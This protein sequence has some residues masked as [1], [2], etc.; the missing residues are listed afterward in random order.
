MGPKSVRNPIQPRI[1]AKMPL[2]KV[3]AT[4]QV[5]GALSMRV[6]RS[7]LAA[8]SLVALC[9]IAGAAAIAAE[10]T[11]EEV[12]K[13]RGL[14]RSGMLYV[15]EAESE[16]VPKVA[17]LQP[18][19]RQLKVQYDKVA[20]VMQSQAE[21]DALDDRWTLVN[22]Q[23]RD[24][25]AEIDAHPPTSNNELKQSWQNLLEAERQLRFQYNELRRE[26]NL[27]YKRL[28]SDSEKEKLQGDFLKQRD[29]FLESSRELRALAGKVRDDYSALS[30]DDA[31]KKAL[32]ALKVSAKGSVNLGPS[33]DFK[34]ASAWLINAVRST[35]PESLAPRG[36]KKNANK[37][38]ASTK[39]K[40]TAPAKDRLSSRAQQGARANPPSSADPEASPK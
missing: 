37:G 5:R 22:E 4:G 29:D 33:P 6:T 25:Q 26:V 12:L 21:Y 39:G 16:F 32:T 10:Q 35:S 36:R 24:V 17:K 3:V 27:R 1:I 34:K 9:A 28:V 30:H 23:L 38:K 2:G 20:T 13:S 14:K 31:V 15:L 18:S 19:Y 11:P 7:R 8:A 40:A